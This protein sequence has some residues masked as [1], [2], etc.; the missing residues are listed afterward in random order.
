MV[1]IDG[2]V[3]FKGEWRSGNLPRSRPSQ[4]YLSRSGNSIDA[5]RITSGSREAVPFFIVAAEQQLLFLLAW[6]E[7]LL[8][9]ADINKICLTNYFHNTTKR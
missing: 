8:E 7:V 5:A 1:W 4:P 6:P 3:Q 9:E 2:G